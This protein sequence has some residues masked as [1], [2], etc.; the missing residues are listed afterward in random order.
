MAKEAGGESLAMALF[1]SD[2]DEDSG[3]NEAK[4]QEKEKKEKDERGEEEG[5][6]GEEKAVRQG[7]VDVEKEV[8]DEA[9][10]D[11]DEE[12]DTGVFG[13]GGYNHFNFMNDVP[14]LDG[15]ASASP[16]VGRVITA[17][18]QD[19]VQLQRSKRGQYVRPKYEGV[20]DVEKG[21]IEKLERESCK[22][23]EKK[24]FG[25]VSGSKA[26]GA[27]PKSSV[28]VK[29]KKRLKGKASAKAEPKLKSKPKTKTKSEPKAEPQVEPEAGSE[30]GSEAEPNS[31]SLGSNKKPRVDAPAVWV[32]CDDESDEDSQ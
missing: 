30:A 5:K 3:D 11:D 22:L 17:P 2:D 23:I 6:V 8:D 15:G 9:E 4:Q 29:T 25:S 26:G 31:P 18:S 24:F 27:K 32:G 14:G 16:G 13:D 1:A 21:R 7:E 12:V 20:D 19:G 28:G 10:V